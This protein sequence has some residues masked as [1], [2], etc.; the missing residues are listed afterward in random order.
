M[1]P[2]NRFQR[3]FQRFAA[4]RPV[5]FVFRH[6]AHHLDRVAVKLFRG[7]TLSGTLA[8]IPNIMLTT[9]GAR[10]GQARTV[11]LIG[12]NVDGA[13]AVVG[14]RFGSEEHPGWYYNLIKDPH[15]VLEV[16]G[17][18]TKVVAR[19][20]PDG[21]EY[22]RLMALADSV[23]AGYAKYRT[24]IHGRRIPIFVLEPE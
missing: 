18:S 10:S 19:S 16:K 3:T 14:T 2:P 5:A 8:G 17:V 7:R 9:T 13:V 20:V 22:D 1:E 11:P 12:L 4:L 24:R 6:A 15:A 21:A 23:Y